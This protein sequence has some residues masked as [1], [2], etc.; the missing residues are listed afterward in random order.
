VDGSYA[1]HW[2]HTLLITKGDP[3]ILTRSRVNVV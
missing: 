1:A 2:E 3:E